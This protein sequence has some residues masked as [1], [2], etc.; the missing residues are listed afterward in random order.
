[1]RPARTQ[2]ILRQARFQSRY[3]RSAPVTF[4]VCF[5]TREPGRGLP[6]EVTPRD[7]ASAGLQPLGT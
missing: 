7:G 6:E 1:M 4:V 3:S 5:T 2:A